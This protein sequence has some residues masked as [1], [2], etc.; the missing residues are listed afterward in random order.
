MAEIEILDFERE[1]R[2]FKVGACAVKITHTPEKWEIFRNVAVFIKEDRKWISFPNTK[3]GDEWLPLYER[4][5]KLSK[6]I[7]SAILSALEKEYI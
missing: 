3:K 5:P 7:Y 2:G 4:Q 6:E 1:E